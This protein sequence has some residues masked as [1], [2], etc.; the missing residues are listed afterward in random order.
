MPKEV[1][2]AAAFTWIVLGLLVAGIAKLVAWDD[3]PVGWVPVAA[4]GAAGALLGGFLR[5][6]LFNPGVTPGFDPA[7]L[8]IAIAG[9]VVV[10]LAYRLIMGRKFAERPVIQTRRAA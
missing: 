10:L 3:A 6:R 2:M 5:L 8:L 1:L 7:A 9:A 4:L